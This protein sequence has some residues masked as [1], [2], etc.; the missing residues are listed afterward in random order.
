MNGLKPVVAI[1]SMAGP[2]TTV[3]VRES[4]T[5]AIR[6]A[7]SKAGRGGILVVES[8]CRKRAAVFGGILANAAKKKALG[9]VV[10][11][12]FV[13]DVAEI[14]ELALPVLARGLYP[15]ATHRRLSGHLNVPVRCG[16]VRVE[17]GDIV[18][19]DRDGVVVLR[20]SDAEGVVKRGDRIRRKEARRLRTIRLMYN[21]GS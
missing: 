14:E 15:Y 17:P 4:S 8:R 16:G 5:A 6:T 3:R 7:I 21:L 19:A 10:I 9:G 1:R 18:V 20:A 11:D 2:A 12:G 13:R